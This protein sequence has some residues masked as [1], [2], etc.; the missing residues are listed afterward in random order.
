VDI[1]FRSVLTAGISAVTATAIVASPVT[2][3]PQTS[4]AASSQTAV[5][6]P[7]QN[8]ASV[9]PLLAK[10]TESDVLTPMNTASN[11]I[12]EVYAFA[13]Y[14]ADY[15]VL[16]L[17]PWALGWVPFGYLVADQ[18]YIWY[19]EVL[20]V[21]DAFVYDLVDPVV[22]DP[23]NL[24]AWTDGIGAVLNAV[25]VGIADGVRSEI[26][27]VL[28]LGWLPFPIPPLPW[29]ARTAVLEE[30]PDL[31]APL[32]E[33]LEGDLEQETSTPD[34]PTPDTAG[35]EAGPKEKLEEKATVVE[36]AEKAEELTATGPEQ[37]A[38]EQPET[39]E[40]AAETATKAV[41]AELEESGAAQS[42]SEPENSPARKRTR[43]GGF[44]TG[45]S[46][47]LERVTAKRAERAAERADRVAKRAASKSAAESSAG[48]E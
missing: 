15:L 45:L 19:P 44:G 6:M 10:P 7:V 38:A 39:I 32:T 5:T 47:A 21:T 1:S 24:A 33:A 12:D 37:P 17:A 28:T 46:S 26:E 43:A 42:T 14:W 3:P 34:L 35:D 23:L 16:E 31:V 9:S 4:V 20:R 11:G 22:N 27:Y 18:I 2:T 48:D 29:L 25:A 41:K 13:K 8:T 36:V 40:P 30:T